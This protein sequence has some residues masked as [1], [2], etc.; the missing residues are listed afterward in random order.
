MMKW[1]IMGTG[2]IAN[3]FC[4]TLKNMEDMQI[5]AIGSRNIDKAESFADKFNAAKHYGSY[6]EFVCDK[7][8]DVIYVAT[9]IAYHYEHVKLCLNAG[10]HVLCEKAFTM[11]AEEAKE[12]FAIAKH[13]Q[14]FLMEALWTKCQPVYRKMM[15]WKE[16]GLLGD[17]Q[18]V[19][20]KFYTAGGND[21][22]LYKDKKQGGALYD[23]AIYPLMYA[24]AFLGYQPKKIFAHAVIDGDDVDVMDS[25][26]LVYENGAFADLTAGLSCRRQASLYIHGSKGRVLIDEEHFYKAQSAILYSVNNEVIDGIEAPFEISGYEYEAMEVKDCIEKGKTGSNLIPMEETIAIIGLLED[27]KNMLTNS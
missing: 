24:C 20:A 3:V 23:L 22:R 11:C 4:E 18:G 21:H 27:I 5:Y 19:E 2:R 7:D 6:E 1:G 14:L 10:K 26:Q 15:E 25:I 8:I 9:P 17:I 12:L 13:N 16:Q